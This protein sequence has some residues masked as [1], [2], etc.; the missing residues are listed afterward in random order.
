MQGGGGEKSRTSALKVLSKGQDKDDHRKT[1]W[2]L[3]WRLVRCVIG[4]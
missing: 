3:S 4:D 2:V 1:M